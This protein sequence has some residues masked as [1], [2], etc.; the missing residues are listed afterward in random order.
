MFR[1][2]YESPLY[3]PLSFWIASAALVLLIARRLSFLYAYL[4][5]FAF[6]IVAD[7]TL[8]GAWS[9]VPTGSA[10]ATAISVAFVVLGD[11]RYFIVL[12]RARWAAP[13]ARAWL[14]AFGLATVVP[15]AS[16]LARLAYPACFANPRVTFLLYELI[17]VAFAGAL[18]AWL[19]RQVPEATRRWALRATEFELAQYALW[20]LADVLILLGYDAGFAVRLVPNTMYYVLYL[21]FVAWASPRDL[22][23][24]WREAHA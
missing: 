3:D 14:A 22:A 12:A 2:V 9:P 19:P 5:V 7:A 17:F 6:E 8:T 10:W 4:V 21:P 20:A 24:P 13:S 16:Y 23:Q 11:A 1:S 18:R 15:I